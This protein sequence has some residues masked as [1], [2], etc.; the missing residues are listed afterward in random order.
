MLLVIPSKASL[1][2]LFKSAIRKNPSSNSLNSIKSNL[3]GI[4][5]DFFSASSIL[6]LSKGLFSAFCTTSPVK[7]YSLL[8]CIMFNSIGELTTNLTLAFK[9]SFLLYGL[10]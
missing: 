3:N 4:S 2:K 8:L 9:E 7:L 10:M 1:L 5:P 6:S